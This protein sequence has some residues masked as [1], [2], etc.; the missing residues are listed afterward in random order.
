MS[1]RYTHRKK[2]EKEDEKQK[3]L[4]QHTEHKKNSDECNMTRKENTYRS[5]SFI[6]S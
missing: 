4:R 1:T 2:L 3:E 5:T 6:R